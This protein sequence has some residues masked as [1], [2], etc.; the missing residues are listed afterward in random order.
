[1]ICEKPITIHDL[2]DV[3]VTVLDARDPY[4]FAHS[5][6]VA[7]LSEM[8]AERIGLRKEWVERIH[9]AAHLHDIGKIGVPDYVLHKDG[10]LSPEEFVVMKTHPVVGHSIVSKLAVL[11]DIS[12]YIRHHHERVDG[13][14]YPDGL[15]GNAIPMGA[16]IIAVAD[17]FDAV[18]SHRSYRPAR[19]MEQAFEVISACVG[20]QLCE[21]CVE[22][23]LSMKSEIGP[24]LDRVNADVDLAVREGRIGRT[25]K[26]FL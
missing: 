21:E 26:S 22:C 11:E 16:R 19:S 18:T 6:R 14:G 24:V 13:K 3:V 8:M 7:E 5:W 20:T 17:T 12:L 1:M 2:V 23:F 25:I 10:T 15:S 9:V 4:T